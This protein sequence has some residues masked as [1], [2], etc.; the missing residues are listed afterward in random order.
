MI[1]ECYKKLVDYVKKHDIGTG[2]LLE[3]IANRRQMRIEV[4]GNKR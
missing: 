4:H 1:L 2:T 3:E